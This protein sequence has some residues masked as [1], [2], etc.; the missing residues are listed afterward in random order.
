VAA[1]A[2]C[3]RVAEDPGQRDLAQLLYQYG[4][5]L[6]GSAR[7]ADAAVRFMQCA[8]EFPS[9]SY[10]TWS[11]METAAI[12]RELYQKP[13]TADR[14]LLMAVAMAQEQGDAAAAQ[15]ARAML[16]GEPLEAGAGD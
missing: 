11:I 4:R 1:L 8:I 14:L 6:A 13:D 7:E 9:T 15:R 16:A 3:Q 10:A 12:Y 5:A 2:I